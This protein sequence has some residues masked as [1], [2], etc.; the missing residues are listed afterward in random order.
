MADTQG[1]PAA[2]KINL[3]IKETESHLAEGGLGQ[4]H[5]T[6]E[7]DSLLQYS[8]PSSSMPTPRPA[9]PSPQPGL[10]GA[11]FKPTLARHTFCSDGATL[12]LTVQWC[13][14]QPHVAPEHSECSNETNKLNLLNIDPLS[15]VNAHDSCYTRYP[16]VEIF[17]FPGLPAGSAM[18]AFLR[19]N[20]LIHCHLLQ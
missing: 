12:S 8:R 15:S 1:A 11:T 17:Y 3:S 4:H 16:C 14:P 19:S 5:S 13:R 10:S 6:T 7:Q 20:T 9:L 2:C 18:S